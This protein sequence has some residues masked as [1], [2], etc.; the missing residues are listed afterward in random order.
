MELRLARHRLEP[1]CCPILPMPRQGVRVQLP[2]LQRL[3]WRPLKSKTFGFGI[4]QAEGK[5]MLPL[6]R[7]FDFR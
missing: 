2:R 6:R 3:L 4:P 5:K 7:S 1:G